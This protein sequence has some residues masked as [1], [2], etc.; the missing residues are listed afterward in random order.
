VP[1]AACDVFGLDRPRQTQGL[2]ELARF[3]ILKKKL[4]RVSTKAGEVPTAEHTT[5]ITHVALDAV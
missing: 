3:N 5:K 2:L 1:S 4:N